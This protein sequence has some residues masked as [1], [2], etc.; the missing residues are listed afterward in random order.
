MRRI[1]SAAAIALAF[2]ACTDVPVAPDTDLRPQF[3]SGGLGVDHVAAGSGQFFLGGG[4]RIL[5]SFG[6]QEYDDRTSTGQFQ[7]TRF[8]AGPRRQSFLQAEVTCLSVAEFPFGFQAWIA[9]VIKS[10]SVPDNVGQGI[11]FAVQD[12]GQ[13]NN[14][15]NPDRLTVTVL[16]TPQ[17]AIDI[18]KA[19]TLAGVTLNV[20]QGNIQVR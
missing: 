2:A 15:P 3:A 12:R 16:R 9:G 1:I 11:G 19:N 7:F 17:D 10:S 4:T 13:G 14:A 8:G 5:F 20:V 6:A 18:C